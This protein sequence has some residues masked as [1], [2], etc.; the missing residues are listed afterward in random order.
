[1]KKAELAASVADRAGLTNRQAE[2]VINALL[3]CVTEALWAGDKIELR[4]FGSFRIRRRKAREGRNPRTGEAVRVPCKKV[5]YFRAG[6]ELRER[7]TRS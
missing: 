1:M 6:Q 4:G 7:L 2:A 3:A 5:P